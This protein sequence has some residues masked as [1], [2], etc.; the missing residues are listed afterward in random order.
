TNG[1]SRGGAMVRLITTAFAMLLI[2]AGAA[3]A[4]SLTTPLVFPDGNSQLLCS[5]INT[6]AE[7]DVVIVVQAIDMDGNVVGSTGDVSLRPGAVGGL[8]LAASESGQYCRFDLKLATPRSVRAS[9]C[10]F[11]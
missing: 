4:R 7:R 3:Q 8:N 6:D 5:I 10:V 11:Q 1:P 9:G 2:T